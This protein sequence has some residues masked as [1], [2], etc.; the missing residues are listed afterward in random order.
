MCHF[1]GSACP[2]FGQHCKIRTLADQFERRQ[3]VRRQLKA[4][5]IEPNTIRISLIAHHSLSEPHPTGEP[6]LCSIHQKASSPYSAPHNHLASIKRGL[7]LGTLP[8]H[9]AQRRCGGC[10]C[11]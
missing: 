6:G 7:L 5:E 9:L 1:E 2:L 8:E 11:L 10:V 4:A 3:C